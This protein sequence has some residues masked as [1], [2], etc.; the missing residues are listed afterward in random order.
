MTHRQASCCCGALQI[1]CAG[2]PVRISM[3]HCIACQ[4]RTGAPFGAQSR[5]ARAQVT[6]SGPSSLYTR[7]ADSGNTV[8]YHF[9][10]SCGSTVYWELSGYPDL[11]AVALGMFADPAFPPPTVSV[12]E[13]T[14]HPW[15]GHIADCMMEHQA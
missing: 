1:S 3:C 15:T 6:P 8:T 10:P 14:R 12:W 7:V 9:C 2:A 13:S 11:I 5:Y 4:R